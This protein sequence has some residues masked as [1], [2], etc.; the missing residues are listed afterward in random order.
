MVNDASEDDTA[1]MVA[2]QFPQVRLVSKSHNQGLIVQRNAAA[3]L[4]ET[5]F[6][7]SLDDDAAFTATDTVAQ[8]VAA[9]DH[10]R[11]GAVA[12]PYRD[13]LVA[14]TVFQRSTQPTAR[15]I[16]DRF[17]GTAHALRRDV[18]LQLG[19][20]RQMLVHQGEEGDY[21]IR[22]LAAGYVTRLGDASPID[23]YIS[24]V[25]SLTRMAYFGRRND[26]LFAWHNIP[27]PAFPAHLAATTLNGLRTAT[28]SSEPAAMI[29]GLVDGYRTI[30][31]EWRTR[32]PVSN[33]IYRLHRKLK[34][35]PAPLETLLK[36]LPAA[37]F[38]H[39]PAG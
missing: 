21:C 24:P 8:T 15:L 7:V 25:R 14:P 38:D 18:F 22:M 6:I 20:Y 11:I 28:G 33:A 10:P 31:S 12:M 1:E 32:A 2:R 23:H 30:P 17:I 27:M 13:V 5:P 26:V 16:A 39:Q 37:R 19:G 3:A 36:Q 9:F 35:S 34:R 29:R 4:V